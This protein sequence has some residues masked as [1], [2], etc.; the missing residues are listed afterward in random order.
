M[1]GR[2]IKGKVGIKEEEGREEKEVWEVER[3]EREVWEEPIT[4]MCGSIVPL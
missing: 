2:R 1:G 3:G 4:R